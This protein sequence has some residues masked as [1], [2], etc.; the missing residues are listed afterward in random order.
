MDDR[1]L[2]ALS[3]VSALRRQAIP[4]DELL[5][6]IVKAARTAT[7]AKYAAMGVLTTNVHEVDEN[8]TRDHIVQFIYD[9]ID[10]ETASNIGPHPVGRGILGKTIFEEQ[11]VITNDLPAHPDSIPL[12]EG[13]PPMS[14]FLGAP[15]EVDGRVFG[16][17]YLAEKPEGFSTDDAK[18]LEVLCSQAGAA[19]QTSV[20]AERLRGV[21]LSDE[22]SRIARDMHDGVM[23][24]LFSLGMSLDLMS[25]TI[26]VSSP[27]LAND[28][29]RLVDQVDETIQS[30]RSTIYQ[31]RDSETSDQRTSL[32]HAAVTLAREFEYTTGVR[33]SIAISSQVS[34]E[35]PDHLVHDVV[36]LIKEA[37]HNIRKHAKAKSVSIRAT[38]GEHGI[39]ITVNDNGCGFDQTQ[40]TVGHG[41]E[42]MA[43]RANLIGGQLRITSKIGSGTSVFLTIPSQTTKE[44]L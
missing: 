22:R 16:N 30:I 26:E 25:Q 12:P 33:P 20:L 38:S 23:Q 18:V 34:N 5:P 42:T 6:K 35:V 15:L 31:L 37:L 36:Y 7:G 29:Q 10:D 11:L 43:E 21:L 9:G 17:L 8:E 3:E 32:Q 39:E 27:E 13:H 19:I 14:N 1:Y 2:Y 4:M 40:P 44:Q 41:L 24:N 28:L